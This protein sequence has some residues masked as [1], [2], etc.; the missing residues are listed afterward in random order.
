MSIPPSSCQCPND[1][2]PQFLISKRAIEQGRNMHIFSSRPMV[3]SFK[4]A[5]L[6]GGLN[7]S[8][9][10]HLTAAMFYR[11]LD[12]CHARLEDRELHARVVLRPVQIGTSSFNVMSCY[13]RKVE[14]APIPRDSL[15]LLQPGVYGVFL[16]DE[17]PYEGDVLSPRRFYEPFAEQAKSLQTIFPEYGTNNTPTRLSD[18]VK[19]RDQGR[20]SITGQTGH[21]TQ[22]VWIYPPLASFVVDRLD[23]AIFDKFRLVDNLITICSSLAEPFQRN[24]FS[25]DMEDGGR[26]IKFVDLPD[27]SPV[28]PLYL[29]A[30]R[31]SAVRFWD[32]NFKYTLAVFLP[33]GD[34]ATTG[35]YD[36]YVAW[37]EELSQSQANLRNP[38]WQTALGRQVLEA[39][40]M[41]ELAGVYQ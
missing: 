32:L 6:V 36:D 29:P 25:V 30:P 4:Q 28:L 21:P 17:T 26:I 8:R 22:I 16:L 14:G 12:L 3:E 19:A 40:M 18:L 10:R 24:A 23:D 41:R 34:P 38:K 20:C 33:A 39:Y 35:D 1:D 5:R 27:E 31:P 2:M 11:W 13:L 37:M 7:L 15:A 9:V